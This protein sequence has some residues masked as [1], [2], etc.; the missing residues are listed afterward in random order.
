VTV[1]AKP[2]PGEPSDIKLIDM[3][4]VITKLLNDASMAVVEVSPGLYNQG[5][6]SNP[7]TLEVTAQIDPYNTYVQSESINILKSEAKPGAR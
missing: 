3:T 5:G 4:I 1:K 2:A 7:L 6:D